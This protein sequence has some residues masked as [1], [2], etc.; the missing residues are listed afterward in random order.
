M[1]SD[2]LSDFPL[3]GYWLPALISNQHQST[4]NKINHENILLLQHTVRFIIKLQFQCIFLRF[5][6]MSKRRGKE[7]G[8]K[9]QCNQIKKSPERQHQ[10]LWGIGIF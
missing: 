6:R 1:D 2:I 9:T 4:F 7:T 10:G 8:K 5:C 3:K